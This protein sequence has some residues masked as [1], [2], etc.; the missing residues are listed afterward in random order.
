MNKKLLIVCG[1]IVIIVAVG[2]YAYLNRPIQPVQ[3]TDNSDQIQNEPLIGGDHDEHGCLPSAGYTWSEPKQ[4]CVRPW[5]E[6]VYLSDQQEIQYLVAKKYS[7][8]VADVSVVVRKSTA[9]YM[10]GGISFTAPNLPKPG[11]G[12]VFLAAKEGTAWILVYSG[13]G[14]IDCASIKQ[15]YSFPKDM[16]LGFC[17]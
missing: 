8:P 6:P 14:S 9:D 13:N 16:L 1:I 4:K 2:V 15:N 3:T 10:S 12:G 5:E 7:K 11:E 17:D